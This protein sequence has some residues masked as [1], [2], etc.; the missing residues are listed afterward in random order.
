M[1]GIGQPLHWPSPSD[2]KQILPIWGESQKDW[3]QQYL[4]GKPATLDTV[5]GVIS[6]V[7]EGAQVRRLLGEPLT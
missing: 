4:G 2:P 5:I 3:V 1:L 7:G 6:V